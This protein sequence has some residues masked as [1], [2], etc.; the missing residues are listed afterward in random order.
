MKIFYLK[1]RPSNHPFPIVAWLIML[2]QGM[3]PWRKESTSHRALLFTIG[4]TYAK[5]YDSNGSE[6][7]NVS[8][9]EDFIT[10]YEIIESSQINASISKKDIYK[11]TEKVLNAKYDYLQVFGLFLKR[12]IGFISFNSIGK[13]YK[14]M[15]CNELVLNF[16][17]HFKLSEI[18]VK[19]SD[20]WDLLMTDKLVD[21][22]EMR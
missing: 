22:I 1:C 4:N 10:R 2:F 21:T 18:K 6:G 19:D 11:W 3:L 15:T 7:V 14:A 17:Q 12:A 20:N 8:S 13:N 5:V 9:F 16:I